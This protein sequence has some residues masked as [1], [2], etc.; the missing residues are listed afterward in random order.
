MN[1]DQ[2][3]KDVYVFFFGDQLVNSDYLPGYISK[4]STNNTKLELPT[5]ASNNINPQK[6]SSLSKVVVVGVSIGS[7]SAALAIVAGLSIIYKRSKKSQVQSESMQNNLNS[8]NEVQINNDKY[9]T[10]QFAS[11]Q[12]QQQRIQDPEFP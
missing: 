1:V 7:V 8:F 11:Q 2:T 9:P 3:N 4:D 12:L 10:P 6:P 5:S